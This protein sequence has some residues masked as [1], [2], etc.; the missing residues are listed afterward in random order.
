MASLHVEVFGIYGASL[1]SQMS[2]RVREE[3]EAIFPN[4]PLQ[5]LEVVGVGI[6][7]GDEENTN[8]VVELSEIG[9]TAARHA[10]FEKLA[11]A[12]AQATHRSA[13][14]VVFQV[15]YSP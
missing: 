10:Q 11:E 7:E 4:E 3:F 2:D 13:S 8:V 5:S 9:R 15:R 12:I 14:D 1:V 6:G